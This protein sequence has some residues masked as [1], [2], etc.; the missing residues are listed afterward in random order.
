[1]TSTKLYGDSLN[2]EAVEKAARIELAR[3]KWA[4]ESNVV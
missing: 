2:I 4:S 1:M 3:R